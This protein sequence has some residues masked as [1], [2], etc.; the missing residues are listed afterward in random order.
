MIYHPIR[1]TAYYWA[2]WES[3]YGLRLR[4]DVPEDL[5]SY[6]SGNIIPQGEDSSLS[7]RLS[8]R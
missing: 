5:H 4:Y 1:S 3:I 8:Y 6:S 7:Q 2:Y